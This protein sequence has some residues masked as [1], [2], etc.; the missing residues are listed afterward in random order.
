MWKVFVKKFKKFSFST[1]EACESI[2][3]P[4]DDQ[5][6]ILSDVSQCMHQY[7]PTRKIQGE[8]YRE[9]AV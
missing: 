4:L 1:Q 3:L 2:E 7:V 9:S 8:D 6:K 5:A